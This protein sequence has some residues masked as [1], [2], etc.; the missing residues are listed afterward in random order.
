MYRL[1]KRLALALEKADELAKRI[2]TIASGRFL[3]LT[4]LCGIDLL[5][6]GTFAGVLGPGQRFDSN[7]ALA[8]FAGVSP[9]EASSA[10]HVP[11]RLNRRRKQAPECDPLPLR[12][13]QGPYSPEARTYLARRLADGKTKKEAS[14]SFETLYR[15]GRVA[16]VD[17]MP[18]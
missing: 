16:R 6:A 14:P 8:A 10:G 3:P 13:H 15:T 5:T 1:T 9:R 2:R 7:A 18:G 4:K 17:R 12:T 11:H